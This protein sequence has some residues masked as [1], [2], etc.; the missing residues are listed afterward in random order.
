MARPLTYFEKAFLAQQNGFFTTVEMAARA[1]ARVLAAQET[2]PPFYQGAG[3]SWE[4]VKSYAQQVLEIGVGDQREF[5]KAF[6][7]FHTA[8]VDQ[9]AFGL[10]ETI[11]FNLLAQNWA[12]NE[13]FDQF[14]DYVFL[15]HG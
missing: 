15:L 11:N 9:N 8:D 13:V 10:N 12:E 2:P 6:L 4:D 14:M 5:A 3:V 1:K 7:Q